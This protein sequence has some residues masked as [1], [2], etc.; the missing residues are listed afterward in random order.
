[1]VI[2]K[3][4]VNALFSLHPPHRQIVMVILVRSSVTLSMRLIKT[5]VDFIQLE[6]HYGR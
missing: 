3:S 6:S 1:M 4:H 2:S 5:V